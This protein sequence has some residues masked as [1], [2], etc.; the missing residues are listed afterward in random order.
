MIQ[1]IAVVGPI[2]D[3]PLW[4][5]GQEPTVDRLLYESDLMRGCARDCDGNRE[6]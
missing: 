2:D 3:Q 4:G 6:T 1:P 5:V